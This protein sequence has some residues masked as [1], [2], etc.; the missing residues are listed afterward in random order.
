MNEDKIC[1]HL[2]HLNRETL[3]QLTGRQIDKLCPLHL[4]PLYYL[5]LHCGQALCLHSVGESSCLQSHRLANQTHYFTVEVDQ[6]SIWCGECGDSIQNL[7]FSF[8]GSPNNEDYCKMKRFEAHLVEVWKQIAPKVQSKPIAVAHRG[9][10]NLGNTCYLNSVLQS[11]FA[12]QPLRQLY[13]EMEAVGKEGIRLG[14]KLVPKEVEYYYDEV[15]TK[16]QEQEWNVVTSKKE[17][18]SA[19]SRRMVPVVRNGRF[20]VIFR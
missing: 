14:R 1:T 5:C 7:I 2:K 17:R 16:K 18:S 19:E 15:L 9:L 12:T 20:N 3:R 6:G 4:L 13:A 8:T 10:L 11:L